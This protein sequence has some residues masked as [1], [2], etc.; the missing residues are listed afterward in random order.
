MRNRE[1]VMIFVMG[2]LTSAEYILRRPYCGVPWDVDI[3]NGHP[4]RRCQ[5]IYRSWYWGIEAESL[6]NDAVEMVEVLELLVL[7][8]RRANEGIDEASSLRSLEICDGWRTS[9]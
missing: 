5:T 7:N 6:I 3:S 4:F 1:R 9:S 8:F 2:K